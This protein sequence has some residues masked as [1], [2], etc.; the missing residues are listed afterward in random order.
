MTSAL[1]IWAN[2]M[3]ISQDLSK[4]VG[5]SRFVGVVRSESHCCSAKAIQSTPVQVKRPMIVLL[6]RL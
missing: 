5:K 3:S 4:A 1:A 6:F 2:K